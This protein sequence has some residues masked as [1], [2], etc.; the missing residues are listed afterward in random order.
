MNLHD[1]TRKIFK[2]QSN[3]IFLQLPFYYK[4]IQHSIKIES[5][6]LLTVTKPKT[7]FMNEVD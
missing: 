6:I 5:A 4:N 2:N 1:I 7:R 3:V